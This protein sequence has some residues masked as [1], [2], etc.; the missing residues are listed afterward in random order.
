MKPL[1]INIEPLWQIS[2]KFCVTARLLSGRCV[3]Y[4]AYGMHERCYGGGLKK[5]VRDALV[6]AKVLGP[7]G[8]VIL[9]VN[10]VTLSR[11][12]VLKRGRGLSSSERWHFSARHARACGSKDYKESATARQPRSALYKMSLIVVKRKSAAYVNVTWCDV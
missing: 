3:W 8:Q 2:G 5:E 7:H 6:N 12:A 10:K 1:V 9:V 11:H 4:K